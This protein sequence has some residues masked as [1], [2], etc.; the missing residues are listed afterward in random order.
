MELTN[1]LE[2]QRKKVIR[3]SNDFSATL[4]NKNG[5]QIELG[6]QLVYLKYF[7]SSSYTTEVQIMFHIG[8][9]SCDSHKKEHD[10][11]ISSMN[12]LLA[13]VLEREVSLAAVAEECT[14]LMNTLQSHFSTYD[15]ELRVNIEK[16]SV[17]QGKNQQHVAATIVKVPS[18]SVAYCAAY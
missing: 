10:R 8:L 1:I 7:L 5:W 11:V 18:L 14:K 9:A 13:K 3:A 6:D 17:P 16:T 15:R 2:N 12:L 4:N